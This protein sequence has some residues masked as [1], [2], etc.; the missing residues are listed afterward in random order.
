MN[1]R[2]RLAAATT[3]AAI[4]CLAVAGTAAADPSLS[5]CPTSAASVVRCID[6]QSTRGTLQIGSL[7]V[8]I[9]TSLEVRGGLTDTSPQTLV[10]PTGTDG[11]FGTPI[12]VPGGLTGLGLPYSQD[13]LTVTPELAGAPSSVT[14]D[15]G[16]LDLSFPLKLKLTNRFLK[17]TCTIGSDA[18]PIEVNLITGTTSPPA[19]NTPIT[20]A[21]GTT[22]FVPRAVLISGS[23]H[24]DNA[25]AASG[26]SGCGLG[27]I[28][29]RLI[30]ARFHVPSAAG[31]NTISVT[32]NILYGVPFVPPPED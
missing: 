28:V 32:D 6:F 14:Y 2:R 11:F 25:F 12:T 30:D 23:T 17:S 29:D 16:T 10:P 9:G 3:L 22:S 13:S 21:V 5:D 31:R 20:G 4:S 7:N 19:P 8:S 26:A 1:V 18:A 15:P 27:T 24:V